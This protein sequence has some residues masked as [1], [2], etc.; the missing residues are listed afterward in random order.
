MGGSPWGTSNVMAKVMGIVKTN[1]TVYK[2]K[3]Y[4]AIVPA[5]RRILKE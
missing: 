2:E 1:N 4:H 3:R 5:W